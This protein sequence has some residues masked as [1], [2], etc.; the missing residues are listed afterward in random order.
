VE[1]NIYKKVSQTRH[2]EYHYIFTR[3]DPRS[4]LADATADI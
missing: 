2:R 3:K 4:A 1:K